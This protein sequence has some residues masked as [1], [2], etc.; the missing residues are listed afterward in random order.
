MPYVWLRYDMDEAGTINSRDEVLQLTMNLVSV[1]GIRINPASLEESIDVVSE[2]GK[3]LPLEKGKFREWF[4]Q[5][6]A[7]KD[8]HFSTESHILHV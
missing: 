1:L 4:I 3:G 6:F 5:E 7:C 8:H 2:H